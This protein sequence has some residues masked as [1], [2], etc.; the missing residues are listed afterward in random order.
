MTLSLKLTDSDAKIQMAMYKALSK[1]LN[2]NLNKNSKKIQSKLKP[3]VISWIK[4]QPEI[5][6]ILDD[7]VFGSL[8]AQFGFI[9]GTAQQAVDVI[10]LAIAESIKID[11]NKITDR[12]SGSFYIYLQP[13]NFNN[14]L[15]LPQAII[16]TLAQPLPWLYWLLTQGNSIIV[17]GYEYEPDISGRSGGG[18]MRLGKA[19]RIPSQFS[20]T[21]EDN[22]ITRA[23]IN[24]DKEL[25]LILQ[26]AIYA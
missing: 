2:L 24:R 14:I 20:G 17:A 19:W 11:F 10:S 13:D 16:P 8:N 6:S 26:E 9:R 5:N 4:E 23:F 3:L 7:G 12:L 18:I 15:S 21:V 22:F 25:S 1:D